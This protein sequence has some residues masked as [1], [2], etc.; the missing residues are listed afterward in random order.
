MKIRI[1][2]TKEVLEQ[3]AMCKG[4]FP[5]SQ[6]QFEQK[7]GVGFNCAISVAIIQL[8]PYAFVGMDSVI[9]DPRLERDCFENASITGDIVSVLPEEAC[10]F[11]GDFDANTP[12]RRARMN[13][14]SFDI[15]VPDSVIE[16]IGIEEVNKI[17]SE[18]KT[19]EAV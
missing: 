10:D 11:I 16:Q 3:S 19:L 17:L 14:I 2:V 15:D 18:S 7:I 6:K 9:F 8:F 12:E 13:P 4:E 5:K 1:H